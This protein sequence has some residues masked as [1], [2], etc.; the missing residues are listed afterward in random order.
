MNDNDYVDMHAL[1]DIDDDGDDDD[2]DDDADDDDDDDDEDIDGHMYTI[3]D[4][5]NRAQDFVNGT[6]D[7]K[8]VNE[9]PGGVNGRECE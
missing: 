8:D 9:A 3:Q 2:D 6:R 7:D 1:V 5:L 4:G